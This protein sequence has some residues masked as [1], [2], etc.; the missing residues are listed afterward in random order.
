MIAGRDWLVTGA[1]TAV[2]AVIF[3]LIPADVVLAVGL[4]GAYAVVIGVYLG[5]GAF[6]LKWGTQHPQASVSESRS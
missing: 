2:L 4:F 6:T 5:I 3:L 1:M